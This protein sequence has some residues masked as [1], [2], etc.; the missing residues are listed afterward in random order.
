MAWDVPTTSRTARTPFGSGVASPAEGTRYPGD[1]CRPELGGGT[2]AVDHREAR[3]TFW[4]HAADVDLLA[5]RPGC[6]PA[7]TGCGHPGGAYGVSAQG[8]EPRRRRTD[9]PDHG[10]RHR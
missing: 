7:L 10:R 4:F 9:H 5:A 2:P 6:R 1:G 3:R 8:G